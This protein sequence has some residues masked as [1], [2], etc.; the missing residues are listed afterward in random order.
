MCFWVSGLG[1]QG[2]YAYTSLLHTHA[3]MKYAYA[4]NWATYVGLTYA[5]AYS[6][7]ETL[8]RVFCFHFFVSLI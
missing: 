6:R 5:H 1:F 2:M 8:I 7:L 3:Y 4:Y